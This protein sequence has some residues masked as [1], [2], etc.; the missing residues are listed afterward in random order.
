[1]QHC[2][3]LSYGGRLL[4]SHA[5]VRKVGLAEGASVAM[6]ATGSITL[7]VST[8]WGETARQ[9]GCNLLSVS[10]CL[11]VQEKLTCRS[12]PRPAS[13]SSVPCR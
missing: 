2:F 9:Q 7:H 4:S 12:A 5:S 13:Q 10:E 1:M 8:H 3:R 6:E 11:K